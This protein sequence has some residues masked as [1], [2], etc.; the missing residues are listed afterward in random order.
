MPD[1]L[2]KLEFLANDELYKTQ[3][4]YIFTPGQHLE[5][6]MDVRPSTLNTIKL[7]HQ[8][9]TICD[10]RGEKCHDFNLENAGFEVVKNASTCNDFQSLIDSNKMRENARAETEMFLKRRF[11]AEDV[12]CYGF[13]LR[14]NGQ[15]DPNELVDLQTYGWL[16][17]PARGVHDFTFEHAPTLITNKLKEAGKES[18]LVPGYRYRAINTW[19][20]LIP[21]LEDNPLAVCD[22]RSVDP[23][24]LIVSDRVLPNEYWTM[25]FFKHNP[26]QR[27]HYLSEQTPD[28]LMLMLMYDTKA[29]GARCK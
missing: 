1:V 2:S 11:N 21:R 22:F 25:Y 15:W 20:P 28:E 24:D 6:K 10:I 4:P 26:G 16:E 8:N 29:G 12:V 18:Y 5:E 7:E 9:V 27:W 17:P 14:H 19:R 13:K 3:R 23:N